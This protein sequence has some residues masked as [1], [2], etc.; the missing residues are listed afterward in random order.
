MPNAFA[1]VR[2][3]LARRLPGIEEGTS[4][5][6]PASRVRSKPLVRMKDTGTLVP[7]CAME[8]RSC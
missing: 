1:R 6:T 3:S 8:G 5:G 4:Y 2:A 7:M